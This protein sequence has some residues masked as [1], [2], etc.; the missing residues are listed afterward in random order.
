MSIYKSHFYK[1]F[2]ALI[3]TVSTV[4][5]AYTQKYKRINFNAPNKEVSK[6][7][8]TLKNE[9]KLNLAYVPLDILKPFMKDYYLQIHLWV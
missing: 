4:N 8:D 6:K 1:I 5:I 9:V 2:I 7:Q 3:I